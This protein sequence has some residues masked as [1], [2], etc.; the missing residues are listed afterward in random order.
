MQVAVVGTTGGQAI[1]GGSFVLNY[2]PAAVVPVDASG[3]PTS[4]S[5]PGL[6]L[7]SVLTNWV[8]TKGGAIGYAAGML[9]GEVPSGRVVL[10]TLRFKALRDG[11]T[12][13]SFRTLPSGYMQLTNG[14]TNLLGSAHGISL[15][16][17]R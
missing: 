12:S 4:I 9:Q 11:P 6:A 5:E 16:V 7:P 17:G 3:N 2:D 15:T 14:G 1:D 10:T 8:D 13:L